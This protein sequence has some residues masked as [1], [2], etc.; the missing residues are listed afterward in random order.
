MQTST[1][2]PSAHV[3]PG[4]NVSA[5]HDG[6]VPPEGHP[7]RHVDQEAYRLCAVRETF[8]ES[9]ILLA[10]NNGFG[11]LLEV[12]DEERAEGR[13]LIHKSQVPFRTWLSKKGGRPDVDGLIPFTRWVTPPQVPKRYST[14][15]YL[16]FLPIAQGGA[17]AAQTGIPSEKEALIPP[18]T[19]DGG[20]E[21]TSARFL[22]AAEWLRLATTEDVILYPPQ[23]TLLTL[24]SQFLDPSV[25]NA[26]TPAVLEQQ[27]R[28]LK[29]FVKG[30]DP[31]WGEACISPTSGGKAPD[32]REILVLN[33]PPPELKGTTR[34][35]PMEWVVLIR[36]TKKGLRGLELARREDLKKHE[37]TK[38]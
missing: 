11:R 29:E 7:D 8:E 20:L 22:P 33:T 37:G 28:E 17:A 32:G 1:A 18:P 38:L 31:S 25:P 19:H 2:F 35:G 34:R 15:M 5:F 26:L 9:G 14:Q 13:E 10:Y 30:G 6:I 3:F 36:P 21:H 23:F 4:G 24:I 12:P 27:R 16:Y